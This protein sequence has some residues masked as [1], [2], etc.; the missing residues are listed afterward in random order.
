[1]SEDV[2]LLGDTTDTIKKNTETSIE[3]NKEVD[4]EINVEKTENMVLSR[5]Q[6]V[7]RNGDIKIANR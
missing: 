5:H 3:A 1:L 2:T 4:P 6:N 7:G